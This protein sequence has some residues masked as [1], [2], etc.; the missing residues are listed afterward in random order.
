V[1]KEQADALIRII[2]AA[3]SPF[4]V[5]GDFNSVPNTYVPDLLSSR[6][7]DC[8]LR[9]GTGAGATYSES[10]P[11]LRIDYIF[12]SSHFIV[13]RCTTLKY[14]TSDHLPVL[15]ELKL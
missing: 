15:A 4:I 3:S 14:R 12:V 11:L 5:A 9:A 10:A 2:G 7:T 1:R 8:F 13:A 6:L